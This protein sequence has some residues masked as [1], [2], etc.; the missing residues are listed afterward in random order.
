MNALI[1]QKLWQNKMLFIFRLDYLG[2]IITRSLAH[3]FQSKFSVPSLHDRVRN[4][5]R[6]KVAIKKPSCKLLLHVAAVTVVIVGQ[7][8]KEVN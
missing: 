7:R 1:K 8:C 6:T 3:D 2:L 4:L 5:S